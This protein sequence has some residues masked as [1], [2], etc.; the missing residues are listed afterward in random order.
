M[1]LHLGIVNNGSFVS[2]DGYKL[3]DSTG[4]HLSATFL[5]NKLKVM[6]NG[7]IYSFKVKLPKKESE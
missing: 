3:Q 1:S 4:T 5:V 7:V 6:I 2:A